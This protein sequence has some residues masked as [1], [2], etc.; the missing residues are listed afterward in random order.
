MYCWKCGAEVVHAQG[1]CPACGTAVAANRP[2]NAA[3]TQATGLD[4]FDREVADLAARI[5]KLEAG[6]PKSGIIGRKFWPRAF[7]ILGH[8]VAA[9]LPL[10]AIPVLL[11]A[12]IAF[13]GL[14][15][16]RQSAREAEA[17]A[18]LRTINV[19][20][21][22][23]FVSEGRYGNIQELVGASMLEPRFL[24]TFSGYNYAIGVKGDDYVATA[25]LAS[26]NGGRYEYYSAADAFVRYSTNPDR[27][28][29]N[30]TGRP[31][32]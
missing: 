29:A 2:A 16:T 17:V 21:T 19:A 13:P 27:A 30:Q 6:L 12:T 1:F 7:T 11:I 15:R 9:S 4:P 22:S 14:I 25:T 32:D 23:Y 10:Y 20:Q 18:H 28:P 3:D 5:S 31:L 24:K 8:N 26:A